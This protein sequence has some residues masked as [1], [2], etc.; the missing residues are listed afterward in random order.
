MVQDVVVGASKLE[1]T[2][3]R[4][5]A[6]GPGSY[7]S[8]ITATRARRR[9]RLIGRVVY[10]VVRPAPSRRADKPSAGFQLTGPRI[11][12]AN[13]GERDPGRAHDDAHDEPHRYDEV[14][15]HRLMIAL[16]IK[17]TD[18][19]A[20]SKAAPASGER[21]YTRLRWTV[22]GMYAA[23]AGGLCIGAAWYALEDRVERLASATAAGSVLARALDENVRRTFEAVDVLLVDIASQITDAGGM[24][25]FNEMQ[26]HRVLR[27]KQ[28]LLPTL[29]GMFVYGPDGILFAGSTRVPTVHLDG[30]RIEHVRAHLETNTSSL[31][32]GRPE[33]APVS[34]LPTIPVTRRI[35]GPNDAFGGVVGATLDP[36]RLEAFYKDLGL[37]PGVV[38]VLL[39]ADGILLARF[40]ANE[41]L[42]PGIDVS[43]TRLF[44]APQQGP[45]GVIRAPSILGGERI[46]AFRRIPELALLVSVSQ[47]VDPILAPWRRDT[48]ELAGGLAAVL[49][50][51][52]PLVWLA[53]RQIAR[54]A[55]DERRMQAAAEEVRR[56]N[57]GLEEMVRERTAELQGVN[58]DLEAFSYSVSHDL[59][60]PLRA[61]RGFTG[62]LREDYKGR[63]PAEAFVLL[64]RVDSSA[65]RMNALID[66]LLGL[67]RVSR[68]DIRR[69]QV[70]LS[71]L[72]AEI[73]AEFA[74]ANPLREVEFSATPG[75]V[76]T[77]DP[78][79]V[80]IVLE[81]L[82]GNA[83][84]YTE[85]H[86]QPRVELGQ[87]PGSKATFYI[88]DNGAGFDMQSAGQLF[89]PFQRLHG[90]G[91]FEGTG[92]GLATVERIVRRHGGRVW[93]EAEPE[94]GAT[95]RFTL[96]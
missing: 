15:D 28:A 77:A 26:M 34:G 27:S 59:R 17:L 66:N 37:G 2:D 24:S 1:L 21:F 53:L 64:A 29:N 31:Y 94:R 35:P 89:R 73:A 78:V 54:R 33:R 38:L 85:K 67:A 36:R 68:Q 88:R 92:I 7:G 40:P 9:R 60:A 46:F 32:V 8:R 69:A 30:R 93:A 48:T 44:P 43:N 5:T 74:E 71:A 22:M 10:S 62:L 19:D 57:E 90:T 47:D 76:A 11:R 63:L 83:W 13:K 41:T 39:R 72:G 75:L 25:S 49:L 56:L 12:T 20:Q 14:G 3:A 16:S 87:E 6:A 45:S 58:E 51:L 84:K 61:I 55:G 50:A 86:P 4:H 18:G 81:N 65:K 42:Q 80:R 79:L 23:V 91:E 96:P 52:F 95:F 70:D 82:I